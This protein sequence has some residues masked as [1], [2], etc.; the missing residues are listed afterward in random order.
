[1]ERKVEHTKL[2]KAIVQRMRGIR[3]NFLC[4]IFTHREMHMTAWCIDG[5][6]NGMK[7]T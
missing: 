2:R 4:R 7:E 6:P 3:K 1:M 5:S